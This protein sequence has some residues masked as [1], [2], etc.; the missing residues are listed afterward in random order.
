MDIHATGPDMWIGK[1]GHLLVILAFVS[2]II[3]TLFYWRSAKQSNLENAAL[4]RKNGRRAFVIHAVSILGVILLV[5][6]ILAAKKYVYSYAY[7]HASNDLPFQYLFAAF[8]EGQEGSTMLWAFWHIILGAILRIKAKKWE[9]PVIGTISLVQ[10]FLVSMLLGIYVLGQRIGV[11]P[12]ALLKSASSNAPIFELNPDFVPEDGR[13]LNELLR[14]Y[15]MV[16]HPPIVFLGFA[17]LTIPFG[18]ALGALLWR[19]GA[20]KSWIQP[21]L[22]WTLLAAGLLGMGLLMGGAWAYES[23]SFGGFWTWD[24][25]E[26]ASLVPWLLLVA[27]LHMMLVFRSTGFSGISAFVLLILSFLFL[28]YSTFLT[29]SGILGD[30]SVHSFTDLGMSGQ[31]L[32]FILAFIYL[33]FVMLLNGRRKRLIYTGIFIL[34]FIPFLLIGKFSITIIAILL[35]SAFSSFFVSDFPR[36]EKEERLW[37]RE[38]WMFIGALI[39]LLSGLHISGATSFPV[40]NKLFGTNWTSIE[41]ESY[42]SI[43]VFPAILLALLSGSML[44]FKYGGN[45]L[46]AST[47]SLFLP[48]ALASLLTVALSLIYDLY[49]FKYTLLLL[50]AL[51]TVIASLFYIFSVLRG[52]LKLGGAAL[53]HLGFALLLAGVVISQSK[54]EI[55]SKNTSGFVYDAESDDDFNANNILLYENEPVQMGE[56][57]VTFE[58]DSKGNLRDAVRVNFKNLDR[59]GALKSDFDLKPRF[60][61]MKDASLVADPAIRRLPHKDL[62]THISLINLGTDIDSTE[63]VPLNFQIGDT[64]AFD[65]MVFI[66]KSMKEG[67]PKDIDDFQKND[68]IVGAD[69]EV[70]TKDSV[71]KAE[72]M[73]VIRNNRIV[74]YDHDIEAEGLSIRVNE[75]LPA[76]NKIILGVKSSKPFKKYILFKAMEFPLINMVWLGSILMFLGFILSLL[77]R[78]KQIRGN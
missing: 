40:V 65:R 50:A 1:L 26:N 71:Y 32:I 28:I 62:F 34:T 16:I 23:L 7:Q 54:K 42:N 63:Y 3:S 53:A 57:L 66:L 39:L 70:L 5:F 30:S 46:K 51:F 17:T 37:S 68:I 47:K 2:A 22:P 33:G 75:I 25:V 67:S 24:P 12:F 15:W 56:F 44:F 43:Q 6:F 61:A 11:S 29:K 64:V 59:N 45:D 21:A 4:W 41:Q 52:K 20:L 78:R 72:P 48:L 74:Q 10:V 38:F 14:N 49:D 36:K 76:E 73:Y 27:A 8:W 9:A 77:H 18:Y 31:L 55:I 58:E 13:G 69:V 60:K 35:L 19:K